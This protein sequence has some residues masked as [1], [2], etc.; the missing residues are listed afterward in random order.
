ML[1]KKSPKGDLESRKITFVLIGIVFVLALVYVGF[2]LFATKN[3]KQILVSDEPVYEIEK[4]FTLS[5]DQPQ[6]SKPLNKIFVPNINI[7][8]KQVINDDDWKKYFIQDLTGDMIIPENSTV[9]PI[10]DVP[11]ELPIYDYVQKMPEFV[12][13]E[14][15]MYEFLKSHIIYPKLAWEN[16][17]EGTVLIEFVVE[18]DGSISNIRPLVSANFSELNEE[19][20]RVVK[21]FP[22]FIPGMQMGKPMRV[23]YK[24]PIKFTL[25]EK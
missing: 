21:M 12:G 4:D 10:P 6:P 9:D 19:A 5:T 17:I 24:L 25:T 23:Y 20:I 8:D 3:S 18:K 2:E 1:S 13:G 15:A 16:N 14:K 7:V 22:K 11:D